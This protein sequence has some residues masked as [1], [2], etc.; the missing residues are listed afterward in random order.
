V[1]SRGESLGR[2]CWAD[3]ISRPDGR[4]VNRRLLAVLINSLFSFW[5]DVSND[6]GL[7][8]LQSSTWFKAPVTSYSTR[9]TPDSRANIV[10]RNFRRLVRSVAASLGFGTDS[11]SAAE[12][13]ELGPHRRSPFPSPGLGGSTQL[14][15]NPDRSDHHAP[16]LHPTSRS[17]SSSAPFA[18]AG[19][20]GPFGLRSR[21]LFPDPFVYYLFILLDLVLRFTWSLKLSSHLHTISEIES[22]V[23]IMEA[24]ELG[25]RWMWV[26]LRV[27]WEEVKR[28][29]A[30]AQERRYEMEEARRVGVNGSTQVNG[31]GLG[32]LH[33][34]DHKAPIVR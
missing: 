20:T 33:Q 29:D 7:G 13:F 6:W 32:L 21:M 24:L 30:R 15:G 25:R 8:I 5:W 18:G 10:Y 9:T 16:H 4:S 31:L 23:F 14:P 27:E 26:F 2:L 3:F 12:E 17:G 22:G 28:L 19:P 1:V 34:V 11:A